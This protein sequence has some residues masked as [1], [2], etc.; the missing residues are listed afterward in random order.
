MLVELGV[1]EQR[2]AAV[3]EVFSGAPVTI[4]AERF[5]RTVRAEFLSGRRFASQQEAQAA[6]DAWVA[7]YN[8]ERPHQGIGMV[9]PARRF[10]PASPRPLPLAAVVGAACAPSLP[11][12]HQRRVSPEGRIRFAD[13][14]CQVG[15][16]DL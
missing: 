16:T 11:S 1:V 5:H 9:P 8:D 4:V 3:L 7:H 10:A 15:A 12:T 14:R 13:R 2:H 6:L